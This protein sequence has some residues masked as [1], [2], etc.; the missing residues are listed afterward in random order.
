MTD[1]V[2]GS[3]IRVA[4][5]GVSPVCQ[6]S[7]IGPRWRLGFFIHGRPAESGV[8]LQEIARI[9]L[10]AG[11]AEEFSRGPKLLVGAVAVAVLAGGD[12]GRIAE[13]NVDVLYHPLERLL[14]GLGAFIGVRRVEGPIDAPGDGHDGGEIAGSA[15]AL[16]RFFAGADD[17][18]D[19]LVLLRHD[20]VAESLAGLLLP[21]AAVGILHGEHPIEIPFDLV[22]HVGQTVAGLREGQIHGLQARAVKLVGPEKGAGGDAGIHHVPA[23][24][25][26]I[27][28]AAGR[29]L[30]SGF[31]R[32]GVVGAFQVAGR[33]FIAGKFRAQIHG[34]AAALT[35]IRAHGQP[36]RL[37]INIRRDV[38]IPAASH[39]RNVDVVLP[40]FDPLAEIRH[41]HAVAGIEVVARGG[42]RSVGRD[43]TV[44]RLI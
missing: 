6:G 39:A 35:V 36:P 5:H 37:G 40:G 29:G 11:G 18:A 13:G 4:G 7:H 42:E 14:R 19:Q 9:G 24:I 3:G 38:E 8:V 22:E 12:A 41:L 26:G 15:T 28:P 27:V 33:V 21:H 16:G 23:V 10:I 17:V 25:A 34:D 1:G 43:L 2:G 30:R 20:E 31:A 32:G 44:F